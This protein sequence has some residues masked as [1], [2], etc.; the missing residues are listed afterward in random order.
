MCDKAV[1]TYP[2]TKKFVPECFNTQEVCNKAV[3][4]YF[5]LFD[6]ISGWYKT[7]EIC[8]RAVFDDPFL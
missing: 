3:D 2:S 6:S 5:S 4:S 8:N 7:K 1:D